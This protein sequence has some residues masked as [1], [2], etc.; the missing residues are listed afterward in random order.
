MIKIAVLTATRSEYGLLRQLIFKLLNDPFFEFN[1]LVTGTHLSKSYGYTVNEIISDKVPIAA[2]I[3]IFSEFDK[4]DDISDLMARALKKFSEYFKL[5]KYD[6]LLVDGD[7]YETL[8][9]CIAAV[10]HGIKIIHCGGGA[11]TNGVLDEYWRHAITKLSYLHFPTMDVYRDRIIRMGENPKRVFTVGSL[12]L[13]NML[14]SNFLRKEEV[15]DRLGL[16][17]DVNFAL[18]TYHPTI[19]S[20]SVLIQNTESLINA[21]AKTPNIYYIFSKPNSDKGGTEIWSLIKGLDKNIYSNIICFDSLGSVLYL[22]AM[23]YCAF[24]I[25]NSSSGLIEAPSFHVPTINIGKRQSGRVKAE[26]VIDCKADESS[27]IEAIYM[28]LSQPF[29]DKCLTVKN[30][31]GDGHASERIIDILKNKFASTCSNLDK[32]FFDKNE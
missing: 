32:E 28:A 21:C 14:A 11:V 5:N 27:I 7:R 17:Y 15:F 26:S 16:S 9:V 20:L 25:G 10:N 13:D 29:K 6:Y 19:D 24:V 3:P 8:A 4:E 22:S 31:N 30:P 1:L 23:K 12:G 2:E 18:A